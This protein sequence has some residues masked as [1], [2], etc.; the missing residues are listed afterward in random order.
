MGEN[1]VV[2]KIKKSFF[3]I[4]GVT[5]CL[6]FMFKMPYAVT[7][8]V[9]EGLQICFHVILPSL[10]PFMV[11]STY[12]IKSNIFSFA[13]KFFAPVS[14]VLFRQPACTVPVII[15]SVIGGFPV[16]IKM[17]NNL[18]DGGSI[19]QNQAQRLCLFCMNG[20][21]AFIITAVGVN[22]LGSTRAG[23]IMFVS[24]CL[25]SLILGVLTRFL[26]DKNELKK[27][28]VETQSTLSS[29]S[30]A[31]SD[32]LQSVLGICA[33]VVIFSAI[34]SCLKACIENESIYTAFSA[35]LEVTKGCV[36]LAGKM[37]I[38]VITAMIGF[39]G[40]C[41]H[42]QVLSNLKN[43]GLKYS[44]FF[45]CRV[46]NGA[47]ASFISYLLLLVF[48]VDVDVFAS[49][50]NM[51]VNTFSVSLPAF[52]TFMVMC[53]IMIFDIDRKKKIW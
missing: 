9:T 14:R 34:T 15:M 1:M 29:L 48:P 24:L 53:I 5:L 39:G 28:K 12:I 19:T 50:Q 32:A 49:A 21:P 51:T 33:W 45:V 27:Q 46:L 35:F 8:G 31:V 26:G 37:P 42:C 40:I 4:A 47:V 36:L 20:G 44:H 10:F 43:C 22:M 3:Q 7:D 6:F 38:P 16:G 17:V 2:V 23:V 30:S 11:L 52:C 41:V 18:L 13:Y 25:S